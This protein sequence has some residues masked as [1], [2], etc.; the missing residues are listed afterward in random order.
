MKNKKASLTNAD[1]ACKVDIVEPRG[2]KKNRKTNSDLRKR[3]ESK[4]AKSSRR[5]IISGTDARKLVHELQ[6]H[7]IELE[8]QNGEL[9]NANAALDEIR[10]RFSDLYDFAP[11]GY[12]TLDEKGLVLEANLTIAKLTGR[13][14]GVLLNKPFE[15]LVF[16]EDRNAFLTYFKDSVS[17]D[18]KTTCDIRLARNVHEVFYAHMEC[19]GYADIFSSTLQYLLAIIDVTDRLETEKA[20]GESEK[21]YRQLVELAQEGIWAVDAAGFTTFVN[22][23]MAHML[24]RAPQEMMGK[25]LFD[26]RDE[27][28]I[29]IAKQSLARRKEGITERRDMELVHSDGSR[30]H[31]T[32]A[33]SPILGERGEYLGAIAVITNI[34]KRKR[35]EEEIRHNEARM[36]TLLKISQYQAESNQDLLDFTLDHALVLT[37]SK[38]GYIYRYDE[39]RKEFT[40]DTWSKGVM[41]ECAVAERQTVYQLDKTGIWGEAVRQAAPIVVNDFH[42]QHPLKKGYPDGHVTL[43]NFLTVPVVL[44]TRIVGVVGVANKATDYNDNDARQLTLLMDSAWK[45]ME[46][47]RMEEQLRESEERFRNLFESM[48]EG[49]ALCEMLYDDDGKPFDFRYIDVNPAFAR[50]T[51]LPVERVVGQRVRE[52]IPGIEPFWI[53]AYGR[54]VESG[55]SERIDNPVADL[56]RHYEVFAWRS[57]PGRFAA[58]FND[59]TGRILAQRLLQRKS[60]ELAYANE[61]LEAF[62]YSVSHDLREPLAVIKGFGSVLA[63]DYLDKFDGKGRDYL[64]RIVDGADTMNELIDNM[65]NLSKISKQQVTTK[66]IDLGAIAMSVVKELRNAAPGRTVDVVISGDL[67]AICDDQLMTIALSNLI[68]NAWKYTSKVA[69]ARIEFG[70]VKGSVEKIFFVR[71]N[72]AGFDMAYADR[73][74]Q[75]FRRMHSEKEF[76]GSGIGLSIVKR[77]VEKHGGKIWAEA[78]VEKGATFFFRLD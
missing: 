77:I 23:A 24:G 27:R 29:E 3:A 16:P 59:I 72:G 66:D 7:Q 37:G 69:D 12:V 42:A 71:D 58:V 20:L 21:K 55:R 14:R 76:K 40:L 63:E 36:E 32:M 9:H 50:L 43:H 6:V 75:P 39:T 1:K 38:I 26:F 60:D 44:E 2:N 62:S 18:A 67:S 47:K 28:E 57:G 53:E 33:A 17:S 11:V 10:G 70:I 56:E 13:S 31:T 4:L 68:G 73:L 46:R 45:I 25:H 48:D 49:F 8:M 51:G 64:R 41:E 78:E 30:I 61:E 74:F 34:T 19:A 65:L 54:I 5:K 52:I 15:S 35:M 22:P